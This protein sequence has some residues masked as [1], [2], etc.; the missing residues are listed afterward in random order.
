[1]RDWRAGKGGG[2]MGELL[3]AVDQ[4]EAWIDAGNGRAARA[5][6]ARRGFDE[7]LQWQAMARTAWAWLRDARDRTHD[8]RFA[9]LLA[10]IEIAGTV[11]DANAARHDQLIVP[12]D[13]WR[14]ERIF[15]VRAE[16]VER[17]G[18]ILAGYFDVGTDG[19]VP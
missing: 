18:H 14:R 10:M 9:E 8:D 11:T 3:G 15:A 6:I 1:M 12:G 2:V 4:A 7:D 16:A 19:P 5:Q 13:H 17:C